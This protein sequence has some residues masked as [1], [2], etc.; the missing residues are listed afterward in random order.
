MPRKCITKEQLALHGALVERGVPAQLEKW[1]GHKHIDIA[2]PDV[3][4]NLEVDGEHHNFDKKYALA[5]LKR[6]FHSFAK[7][8]TTVR[9]PNSLTRDKR[10]IEETADYVVAL[11]NHSYT[12]I[13]EDKK[14]IMYKGSVSQLFVDLKKKGHIYNRE[15]KKF[16][17]CVDCGEKTKRGRKRCLDCY[18]KHI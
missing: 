15:E 14:K 18:Y 7:G 8:Y 16:K 5:D 13:E 11:L 1:D 6:T 10:T 2:I 4:I 17:N 3:K 12:T 9:I